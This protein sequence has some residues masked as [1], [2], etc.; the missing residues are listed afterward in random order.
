MRI[1]RYEIL[2]DAECWQVRTISIR[3][4]SKNPEDIGKEYVSDTRYPGTFDQALR[5]VLD[6]M[7][8]DELPVD[9]DFPRAVETVAHLYAAIGKAARGMA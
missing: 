1:G 5:R 6:L 8:R 3:E 4:K 7:V 2:P 9:A